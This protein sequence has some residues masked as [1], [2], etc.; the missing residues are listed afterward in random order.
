MNS[1]KLISR[2]GKRIVVDLDEEL[3]RNYI[4]L[5]KS[6][7]SLS[8]AVELIDERKLSSEQRKLIYALLRDISNHTGYDPQETRQVM[9]FYFEEMTG[10]SISLSDCSKSDATEFIKMLIAYVIKN[11]IQLKERY[12]YLTQDDYF[13]YCCVKY[14]ECCICGKSHADIHHLNAVGMGRNRRHIDH[15]RHG[16]CAVC[17]QHHNTAH[18]MGVDSFLREFKVLP[19]YL[20][21]DDIKRLKLADRQFIED[22]ERHK[23]DGESGV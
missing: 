22:F 6:G 21:N 1:G 10:K 9:K 17:R 3:N 11:H 19:V 5:I 2:Q 23:G 16:L 14:R 12:E 13:F 8:V 7:D 15:S 20:S 18:Q 4:D